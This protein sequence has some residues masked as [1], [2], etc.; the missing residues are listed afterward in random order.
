MLLCVYFK[1]NNSIPNFKDTWWTLSI[2]SFVLFSISK[3]F[4][5]IIV[6]SIYS[7]PL[8]WFSY[9]AIPNKRHVGPSLPILFIF[10]FFLNS[11]LSL[12][13]LIFAYYLSSVL[14][15][16]FIYS[17]VFSSLAFTSEAIFSLITNSFLTHHLISEFFYLFCSFISPI[18][19]LIFSFLKC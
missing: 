4:S 12:H 2:G 7:F 1:L 13:F 18:T 19:F 3:T 14:L 5:W 9:S 8:F 6:F 17:H 10:H 16:V 11:F 15:V